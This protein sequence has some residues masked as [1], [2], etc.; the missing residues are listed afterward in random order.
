MAKN[1]R[2]N[3]STCKF[4]EDDF[5]S[6][7]DNYEVRNIATESRDYSIIAGINKNVARHIPCSYDGLKPV[8]RRT[9]LILYEYKSRDFCKVNKVS[10]DVMGK[11]HPHGSSSIEEVIGRMGQKWNNNVLYVDPSG[12]Y[13]NENGDEPAAGRYIKT[14]LSKFGHKCFFEDYKY[15]ALDRKTT[16]LGNVTEPEYLPAKYPVGL[17]NPQFSSIGYG[18]AANIAPYNFMEVCEAT[19]KLLKNPDSD[20]NLIPDFPNGCEVVADKSLEEVN[21]NHGRGKVTVKATVDIDHDKNIIHIR[22]LP[23]KVGSKQ[24]TKNIAELVLSKKIEGIIKMDDDT[25]PNAGIQISIMLDKN[26]NPEKMLD[27]LMKKNIGLKSTFAVQIKFIEDYHEKEY[28]PKEYLL[29]WIDFRREILQGMHNKRYV[30]LLS[31]QHMNDVKIFVFSDDNISKTAEIIK[32][33]RDDDD[34]IQKLVKKYKSVNMT[35]MQART[36]CNMRYKDFNKSSYQKFLEERE[37]LKKDIAESEKIIKNPQLIDDIIE[38]ELREGIELF[39]TPRRSKIIYD[40][41]SEKKVDSKKVIIAISKDG[42]VKKIDAKKYSTIGKLGNTSSQEVIPLKVSNNKS[43]IVFDSNGKAS[44]VPVYGIPE[45]TPEDDGLIMARYFNV[46][47][48]IVSVMEEID[49]TEFGDDELNIIFVSKYGFSK[50][51]PYSNFMKMKDL[52]VVMNLNDGDQL[53]STIVE[54][55]SSIRRA[56]D[57]LVYTNMGNG[58]RLSMEDIQKSASSSKGKRMIKLSDDEEVIGVDRIIPNKKLIFYVTSSGKAKV[59]ETKYLPSMD[60]KDVPVQLL[61]LTGNDKLVGIVS[62][63]EDDRVIIYRKVDVPVEISVSDITPSMRVAKAE[64]IV[65]VS[66]GDI[67]VGIRVISSK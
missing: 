43:I 22:S 19:I 15:A 65:K 64:K 33:S 4:Q 56:V 25:S 59:T 2:E 40:K 61:K 39:G 58:I 32:S 28:T 55:V 35:S 62:V 47:G 17:V 52:K 67:V 57:M 38:K 1:K 46:S 63:N 37:R 24:V 44:K 29:N 12:N 20:I 51:T 9:L 31:E 48:Q 3:I 42:F 53:V 34:S 45:M 36:I 18:T 14:R 6:N 41:K 21:Y 50:K 7:I 60:K 30:N 11:Y 27:T 49:V 10:G 26:V 54:H 8:A 5:L 66:K 16:Y 23:L 13:G